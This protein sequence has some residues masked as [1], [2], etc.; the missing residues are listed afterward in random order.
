[1]IEAIRPPREIRERI[2]EE[3]YLRLKNAHFADAQEYIA[4]YRYFDTSA[5]GGEA[6]LNKIGARLRVQSHEGKLMLEFKRGSGKKT[7]EVSQEITEADMGSFSRGAIPPGP[8]AD[9]VATFGITG[10]LIEIGTTHCVSYWKEMTGGNYE[11]EGV[12]YPDGQTMYQIEFR[13]E[14]KGIKNGGLARR[15]LGLPAT[16]NKATSKRVELFN[17]LKVK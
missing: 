11:I 2:D 12:T 5:K 4:D 8:V 3:T 16:P 17:H 7:D 6:A 13:S 15:L 14:T 10:S 1:M 9:K